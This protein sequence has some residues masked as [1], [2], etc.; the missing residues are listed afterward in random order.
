MAN[1]PDRGREPA[2]APARTPVE[3]E[4]AARIGQHLLELG[5]LLDPDSSSERK[6]CD[7][8]DSE[9]KRLLLLVDPIELLYQYVNYKTKRKY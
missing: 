2:P 3:A 4:P 5:R 7:P 6:R 1:G 9:A 8:I